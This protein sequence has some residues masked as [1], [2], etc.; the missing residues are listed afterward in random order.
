MMA[1][2]FFSESEKNTILKCIREAEKNTSGEIRVHM[3]RKCKKDVLD[4]AS[5]VFVELQMHKT[6]SRNGILFYL[7]YKDKQFAILGDVGVH[8]KVKEKFWDEVKEKVVGNF[9]QNHFVDGLCEGI[10][11]VGIEL[12]KHFPYKKNDTNELP[13]QISFKDN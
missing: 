5:E 2:D 1:K 8:Q 4:R 9:M 13:D 11:L 12:K 3:E 7:S 6:Q 10:N